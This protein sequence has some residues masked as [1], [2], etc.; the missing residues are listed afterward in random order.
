MSSSRAEVTENSEY[1]I[2]LNLA[3]DIHVKAALLNILHNHGDDPSYVGLSRNPALLHQHLLQFKRTREHALRSVLKPDHWSTLC[4]ADGQP[5]PIDWD[6]TLIIVVVIN[7]LSLPP[8]QG[9][10]KQQKPRAS[11]TSLSALVLICRWIRN[12]IKHATI[13]EFQ[14]SQQFQ[15]M[16]SLIRRVLANLNYQNLDNFEEIGSSSLKMYTSQ[17]VRFL[18]QRHM[19][20]ENDLKDMRMADRTNIEEIRVQLDS[21]DVALKM[22]G[23]YSGDQKNA[24]EHEEDGDENIEQNDEQNQSNYTGDKNTGDY[25]TGDEH[26]EDGNGECC[27]EPI[28]CEKYVDMNEGDKKA[29]CCEEYVDLNEGNTKNED[30]ASAVNRLTKAFIESTKLLNERIKFMEAEQAKKDEGNGLKFFFTL[31]I[32]LV[33]PLSF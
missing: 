20:L 3:V 15:T 4:P 26:D 25:R 33:N 6:V 27:G 24:I 19:Q 7:I 21:F 17:T 2:K 32:C 22:V 16:W 28:C 23:K 1:W 31:L 11:D 5:N 14:N 18:E 10:W 13:Q 9:G 12:R 8:P 29:E 30:L